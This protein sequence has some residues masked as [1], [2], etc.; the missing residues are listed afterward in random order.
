[1]SAWRDPPRDAPAPRAPRTAPSPPRGPSL[2]FMGALAILFIGLK[3]TGQIDW[4][5]I[6]VLAPLWAPFAIIFGGLAVLVAGALLIGGAI[7]LAAALLGRAKPRR[8]GR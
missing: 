2:T 8:A 1:M 7:A 5:W 4:A 3:L 6:W